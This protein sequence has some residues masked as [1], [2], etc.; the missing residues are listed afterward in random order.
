MRAGTIVEATI[1]AA[2]SSTKNAGS[3][4]DP[5][6]HQTK[7]GNQWHFGMK[8]YVGGDAGSGL[9][10]TVVATAANV[11]DVT[12][13]GAL[14]HGEERVA[15]SDVGSR[16]VDK[17]EEAQGPQWHLAMQPGKRRQLDPKH[18]WAR[19]LEQ[20]EQLKASI[21]PKVEHPCHVIKN[22]F[23]HKKNPHRSYWVGHCPR[24]AKTRRVA[25]A[26]TRFGFAP[27]FALAGRSF[28]TRC[29]DNL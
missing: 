12:R 24:H 20:A 6:M 21:R 5:E 26:H 15:F 9:V 3:T 10:H 23:R 22:L 16:G 2:S 7:T 13:A 25:P 28:L 1:I 14:L 8:A 27:A 11:H 17:H 18:K 19:L 4:P 29:I